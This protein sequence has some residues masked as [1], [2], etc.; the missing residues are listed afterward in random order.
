MLVASAVKV[1]L[2][3]DRPQSP[4]PKA[5]SPTRIRKQSKP[6]SPVRPRNTRRRS[7]ATSFDDNDV[8]L[9]LQILRNLGISLPPDP[10]GDRNIAAAFQDVLT[11]RMM[12]L[13]GHAKSLQEV[14]E[15]SVGSHLHDSQVTLQLLME[16]LLSETP[17]KS[18][19][20]LD[21][22]VLEAMGNLERGVE[23]VKRD[24]AVVNL[25]HLRERNV[26]RDDL[27]ER[28]AR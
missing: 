15:S 20:L 23:E 19:N 10:S 18:V 28:W 5:S 9:E 8:N 25:D 24:V 6:I 13:N 7:S 17:Y 16:S 11:D 2:D 21:T 1:E 4:K 27:V 22:E 12:K 14:S 3:N 26:R